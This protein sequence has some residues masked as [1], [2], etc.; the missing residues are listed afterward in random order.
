MVPIVPELD[1]I[2]YPKIPATIS[3]SWLPP[4]KSEDTK[5]YPTSPVRGGGRGD[6]TWD[7][8]YNI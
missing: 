2:N 6:N 5:S 8:G 1:L 7:A 3:T 4:S